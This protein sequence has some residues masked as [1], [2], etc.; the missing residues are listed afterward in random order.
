MAKLIQAYNRYC[1]KIRWG[2]PAGHEE[3]SAYI[4]ESTGLDKHESRMVLGKLHDAILHY[5]RQG[6]GVAP[7]P[8]SRTHAGRGQAQRSPGDVEIRVQFTALFRSTFCIPC[9]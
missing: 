4:S 7:G 9:G 8:R 2:K 6:R 5:T 3:I 1:P